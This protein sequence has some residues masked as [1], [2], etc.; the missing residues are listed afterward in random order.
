VLRDYH[1]T[2]AESVA[3]ATE[4]LKLTTEQ[5]AISYVMSRGYEVDV[6]TIIVKREGAE[7]ILK[8]AGITP[9]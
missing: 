1:A 6:A 5:Q 3:A 9:S 7:K 2:R 4:D 8:S